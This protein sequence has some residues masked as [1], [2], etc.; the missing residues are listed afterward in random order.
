MKIYI[1]ADMEGIS[2][3]YMMEQ[4]KTEFPNHYAIG[5]KLLMRE[6]NH[7][8]GVLYDEGATEVVVLDTHGGGG[9]I[10]IGD[11]D[12]RA[13]YETPGNGIMPSLD[14]T[15]DGV[16]LLGH[17]SKAGTWNGFLEHTMSSASWF[18]FKINGNVVGEIGIEAAHAGHFGVPVLAV[19]GDGATSREAKETLGDAVEC[20][21]VKWGLGRNRAT[22]LSLE[23]AYACISEALTKAVGN[24]GQLQPY[25]PDLPATLELTFFR[26]DFADSYFKRTDIERVDGRTIRKVVSSMD[27]IN[28][29]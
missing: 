8:V 27:Q 28:F 5:R 25:R 29:Y 18:E 20:A 23:A 6:I 2:G 13:L 10:D 26:P 11:M 14:A 4:V 9:N 3:I 16:I 15:F 17:H 19:T 22:C 1:V 24:I 12:P 7:V 21:V